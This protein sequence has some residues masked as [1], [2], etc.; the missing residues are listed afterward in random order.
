MPSRP[1][2]KPSH[3]FSTIESLEG[4]IAPAVVSL[5][6]AGV[7]TISSDAASDTVAIRTAGGDATMLIVD[8]GNDGTTDFSTPKASFNSITFTGLAGDDTLIVSYINGDPLG[9]KPLNTNLGGDAGDSV[10]IAGAGTETVSAAP[11]AVVANSGSLTIASATVTYS[12]AVGGVALSALASASIATPAGADSYTLGSAST[13]AG[14]ISG[15]SGALSH[16]FT[17]TAVTGVTLDLGINDGAANTAD[18]LIVNAA[19]GTGLQN[20]TVSTAGGGDTLALA[21]PSLNLPTPGGAFT[22]NAGLGNDTVAATANVSMTLSNIALN[23]TGEGSLSLNGVEVANLTGGSGAN[24]FSVGGWSGTGTLDGAGGNDTVTATNDVADFGLSDTS[25]S[26]TGLGALTLAGIEVANLTGGAGANTFNASGWSGTGTL[27]GLGG[28]DTVR[29]INDVADL[30]LTD[31]RLVR[32]SRGALTLAGIDVANL[33]GGAGA[34]TFTVGGW[35]GTGTFDGLGGSDTVAATSDV[36]D[37]VLSDTNLART[38]L[39]TVTL[40]GI[41]IATLTGGAGANAINLAN[42][43][44]TGSFDGADGSDSVVLG[45]ISNAVTIAAGNAADITGFSFAGVES[46]DGAGGANTLTN[47]SGSAFDAA[48]FTVA[49]ITIANFGIVSTPA[50]I[51]TSNDDSFMVTGSGSGTFSGVTYSG[52][53]TVDALSGT[54]AITLTSDDDSAAVV[55]LNAATTSG[56]AFNNIENIDGAGGGNSVTL[57]SDADAFTIS[58]TRSGSGLGIAFTNL[59]SVDGAA[60]SN[61]L[62]NATGGVFAAAT[63]SVAGVT[64]MNFGTVSTPTLILTIGDDNFTVTGNGAGTFGAITYMDLTAIDSLDGSDTVIATG[65]D[66][67]VTITGADSISTS[68]IAFDHVESLDGAGGNDTVVLSRDADFTLTNASLTTTD[69]INFPLA[70]FE[71]ANLTGGTGAN[72]FTV[73]GWTGGGTITGGGGADKIVAVKAQ[74][75]DAST[76]GFTFTLADTALATTDGMSFT[77]AAIGSA[78]LSVPQNLPG[79]YRFDAAAWSRE[80]TFT[81]ANGTNLFVAGTGKQFFNGGSGKDTYFLRTGAD[82]D[83]TLTDLS[84]TDQDEKGDRISFELASTGV[85][86][87]LFKLKGISVTE[88]VIQQ[89]NAAGTAGK[90][91]IKYLDANTNPTKPGKF[92]SPFQNIEGSRFAD[93]LRGAG[94]GSTENVYGGVSDPGVKVIDRITGGKGVNYLLGGNGNK[95]KTIFVK[96]GPGTKFAFKKVP[97]ADAFT[98]PSRYS[99]VITNFSNW[100]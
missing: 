94:D 21:I 66:D 96:G 64:A 69:G 81:G 17:Y 22:Y 65:G 60:G 62:T 5:I 38:G 27:D 37:F 88:T 85:T 16:T 87:N 61:I 73:S 52:L 55:A 2:R 42:W 84:N 58:G 100:S 40:A 83:Y 48:T 26:R 45:P 91:T 74:T 8:V 18:Q 14:R 35:S 97:P 36:A 51:L 6:N 9:S 33:T 29:A 19:A 67:M 11:S 46:L 92:L 72:S 57:T 71:A 39:G 89:L 90:V 54:D 44:G 82:V 43:S 15:T 28:S 4:R 47:T 41:E 79:N 10:G 78:D 53:A 86:V 98:D 49:G 75:A 32:T 76:H 23:F 30:S 80:G 50:L 68:N 93:K 77:L 99:D 31:T 13:G 59:D 3:C 63:S 56:I 1:A 70:G 7:L 25:L 95:Q 34:N 20:L 12:G 24:N